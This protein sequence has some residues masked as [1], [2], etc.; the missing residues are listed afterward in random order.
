MSVRLSVTSRYSV[1]LTRRDRAGF[2]RGSFLP[3][4]TVELVDHTYDGRRVVAGRT[5]MY[6]ITFYYT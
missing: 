6:F 1:E 2:W 3:P 5:Y 4:S